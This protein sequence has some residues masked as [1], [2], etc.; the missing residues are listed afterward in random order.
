MK[1][2]FYKRQ[3]ICLYLAKFCYS[4]ANS[5][6]DIFGTVM[7]YKNGMSIA[8][9]LFVYD[10]LFSLKNVTKKIEFD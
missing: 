7:L 5:L 4:L 10:S 1:E 3:Y 8:L 2:Y 9:I 6:I